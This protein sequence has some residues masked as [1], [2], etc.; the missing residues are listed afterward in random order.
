[1][2]IDLSVAQNGE[3]GKGVWFSD[4]FAAA[5]A[6]SFTGGVLLKVPKDAAVF[7]RKGVP[8]HAGGAGF[9]KDYLGEILVRGGQC[10]QSSLVGALEKQSKM[11]QK[12]LIGAL[13]VADEGV[14]PDDVKKAVAQQTEG[15]VFTLFAASSGTFQT[16]PGENARIR[17]IGVPGTGMPTLV[18]GLRFHVSDQE[19]K[20]SADD[21]LGKAV[22]LD[23][24]VDDLGEIGL[25]EDEKK[26]LRYLDKPRKPDQLERALS[27]RMV[28]GVLR[29]LVLLDRLKTLPAAKG[30]PIPKAT[31]LKG[32]VVFQTGLVPES[33][34]ETQGDGE[35]VVV[36]VPPPQPSPE[37]RP[38]SS[39]NVP[40]GR[41]VSSPNV[42]QALQQQKDHKE[43][44]D[45]LLEIRGIH[46]DLSKKSHYDALSVKPLAKAEEIK[47][48]FH[49]AAKRYHPDAFTIPLAEDDQRVVRELSARVNEAYQ[50]LSNDK[51]R[52][53]YDRLLSDERIK[54]DAR[55]AERI[56]DAEVKHQMGVVMMR[57]KDFQKAREY[58]N[59][60]VESD[61][62]RGEYKAS[63]AWAMYTDAKFDREQALSKG[64]VLLKE[65]LKQQDNQPSAHY[66][67]AQMLKTKGNTTDALFHFKRALHYDPKHL[68]AQREVRLMEMRSSKSDA[69][70][71]TAGAISKLFKR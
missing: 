23:G 28:R 27:R 41:P 18:A 30:I 68:D 61:P 29:L 26:V 14:S 57:K 71:T 40:L 69:D 33:P 21:L 37:R 24:K 3:I 51:S 15:R 31:L 43:Q 46:K 7:F 22:Q 67:L 58:F 2:L 63:L 12:P 8:V 32:N 50:V 54:G 4:L 45:L 48:A 35:E 59:F 42:E 64:L 13:L 20:K 16:A 38:R 17:E 10:A 34:T 25:D 70:D 47:R 44:S 9:D 55:K 65:A 11:P 60:A 1:M 52:V 6:R 36:V 19:L 66:Y 53:E 49:T 39:S 62:D 5:V 56:R